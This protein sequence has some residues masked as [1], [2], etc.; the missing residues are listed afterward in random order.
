MYGS[1]YRSINRS[2]LI[3]AEIR[4]SR[5][6]IASGK[7]RNLVLVSGVSSAGHCQKFGR[8]W[9]KTLLVPCNAKIGTDVN[10]LWLLR[11]KTKKGTCVSLMRNR[12][13]YSYFIF[14][15]KVANEY[16][17]KNVSRISAWYA[18]QTV[19]F[20]LGILVFS[21]FEYQIILR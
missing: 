7:D 18:G 5:V 12:K 17:L 15:Y 8:K 14:Y 2:L 13:Y 1:R 21:P 11:I 20:L 3:H 6:T 19:I 16:L 9:G 4:R 10:N